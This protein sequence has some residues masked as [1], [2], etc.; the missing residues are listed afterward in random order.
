MQ[1][2]S[3]LGIV[4]G[5][6]EDAWNVRCP[7]CCRPMSLDAYL[8]ALSAERQDLF[9]ILNSMAAG[10]ADGAEDLSDFVFVPGRLHPTWDDA[11]QV[12]W[13][14]VEQLMLPHAAAADELP[15]LWVGY[16]V[17]DRLT[18]AREAQ[19]FLLTTHRLVAKDTVDLV[20]SK[21]VERQYPLTASLSE[22][23]AG[24]LASVI[25][26]YDWDTAGSLVD[27]ED[28]DWIAQLLTEA[29]AST[30]NI[31][32]RRGGRL[33]TAPA[34][35]TSVRERIA[36]LGL[37]GDAKYVD[38]NTH[39]KHFA[40]LLK[41]IPIDTD[42]QILASFSDSTLFGAYGLVI[43]DRNLRSRDLGDEA[44]TTPRADIEASTVRLSDG[45]S[46]KILV[47]PGRIHD[48]PAHLNAKKMDAVI[49]LLK[50]WAAGRVH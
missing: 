22:D 1:I 14:A 24:F 17:E 5:V 47:A 32:E 36:E 6:A 8:G 34:A 42:E 25:D 41:K 31:L 43:T 23:A 15:I 40:K 10:L 7:L 11:D 12:F 44:I 46:H 16:H 4:G 37:S 27:E 48:A 3:V 28:S 21:G 45:D 26:D 20:F 38:D 13:Q 29:I 30:V 39:V 35:A 50:D 49:T 33:P 18:K 19:G 9:T 2:D